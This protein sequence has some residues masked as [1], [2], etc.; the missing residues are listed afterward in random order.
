MP[1]ELNEIIHNPLILIEEKSCAG[2]VLRKFT[3]DMS[4]VCNFMV[5]TNSP[6]SYHIIS[7]EITSSLMANS[8]TDANGNSCFVSGAELVRS[9]I[10]QNDKIV[11]AEI[12]QNKLIIRG[13]L[14]NPNVI[15]KE[16]TTLPPPHA[17]RIKEYQLQPESIVQL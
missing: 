5:W 17:K 6:I 12:K 15:L 13:Y 11:W 9:F 10:T 8:H 16:E 7:D 4:S 1:T 14:N 3:Y 2:I